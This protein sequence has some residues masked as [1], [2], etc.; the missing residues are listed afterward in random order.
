MVARLPCLLSWLK[1]KLSFS[2][3]PPFLKSAKAKEPKPSFSWGLLRCWWAGVVAVVA[4]VAAAAAAGGGAAAVAAV[5]AAAAGAAATPPPNT[6]HPDTQVRAWRCFPPPTLYS[7]DVSC[8]CTRPMYPTPPSPQPLPRNRRNNTTRRRDGE[9]Q[10]EFRCQI[11]PQVR[12]NFRVV[13]N[14]NPGVHTARLPD[15]PVRCLGRNLLKQKPGG[16]H[17]GIRVVHNA[18]GPKKPFLLEEKF[19]T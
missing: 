19:D 17:T 15:L 2:T 14:P 6:N 11:L 5:G 9:G 16:V 3:F 12:K 1:N 7:A 18:E 13:H 4:A 10:S 8:R